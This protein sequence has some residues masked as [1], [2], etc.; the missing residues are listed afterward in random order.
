MR[1][2]NSERVHLM[3]NTD[4]LA[5][6]MLMSMARHVDF[7]AAYLA[8]PDDQCPR[9]RARTMNACSAC[10]WCGGDVPPKTRGED[11]R[12]CSAACRHRWHA[13]CRKLGEFVLSGWPNSC[14]VSRARKSSRHERSYPRG[15]GPPMTMRNKHRADGGFPR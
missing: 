9:R 8:A 2:L 13:T 14:T 12:F 1:R 7:T 3:S 15:C 11:R 6:T 4:I 10:P 5:T